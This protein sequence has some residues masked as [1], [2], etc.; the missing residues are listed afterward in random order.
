VLWETW[1]E[2]EERGRGGGSEEGRRRGGGREEGRKRGGGREEGRGRGGKRRR[3]EDRKKMG[4][5]ERGGRG[6]GR[7]R[8]EEKEEEEEEHY[9]LHCCHNYVVIC[10]LQLLTVVKRLPYWLVNQVTC[11]T[12]TQTMQGI[13]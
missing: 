4:D 11:S 9:G 1:K 13:S 10:E 8:K 6:E 5:L 3:K 12:T 2:M 7:W